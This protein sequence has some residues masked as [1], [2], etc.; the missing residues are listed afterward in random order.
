MIL[1]TTAECREF[2][3]CQS[4]KADSSFQQFQSR[5]ASALVF[6]LS[7]LPG[8]HSEQPVAAPFARALG[9]HL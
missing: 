1:I 8:Q 3:N 6:D 7:V 5:S 4:M 2:G 9:S